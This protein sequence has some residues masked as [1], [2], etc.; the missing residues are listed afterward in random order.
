MEKYFNAISSYA[1]FFLNIIIRF[2]SKNSMTFY[3]DNIFYANTYLHKY[4]SKKL[5][6]SLSDNKELL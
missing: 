6:M 1:L 3:N 4:N 2:I 5:E